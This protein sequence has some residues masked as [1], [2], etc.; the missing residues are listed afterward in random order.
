MDYFG[1]YSII[2]L[3]M[4]VVLLVLDIFNKEVKDDNLRNI[5][6]IT[7]MALGLAPGL[8]NLFRTVM[9]V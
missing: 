3:K 9:G 2:P 1:P 4:L 6:K 5:L 8:R 7:V